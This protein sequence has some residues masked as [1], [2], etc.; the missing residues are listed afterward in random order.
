MDTDK[1]TDDVNKGSEDTGSGSHSTD[2]TDTSTTITQKNEEISLAQLLELHQLGF[3][4]VP[5]G[6]HFKPSI[7]WTPVYDNPYHWTPEKLTQAHGASKF[8]NGVATVFGKTRLSDEKGCLYL[9]ALD[10]DSDEV[11]KVLFN[12]ANGGKEYSF[13]A[14]A[15]KNTYV[16]KT[17]KP[18]GFHIYWLSHKQHESV[19]TTDCVHCEFEIKSDKRSGHS[20]LPPSRH[21]EDT[22][23]HYKNYGQQKLF[24]SDNMYDRLIEALKHCLKAKRSGVGGDANT[25]KQKSYT[26]GENTELDDADIQVIAE[27]ILPY[28]KKGRRHPIVFGLSGVLHKSGISRDS[29]IALMEELAKNDKESDVRNAVST[30]EQT[31]GKV[32]N[33]VPGSKYFLE[34]LIAATEDSGIA[35]TILDKIFRIIGK[36]DHIQWLT[37]EIMNEY[38]FK[39]MTDNED[40]Y[41]YDDERGQEWCIKQLSQ[42]LRVKAVHW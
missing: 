19:L 32:V 35:K 36:G 41:C 8:K 2:I 11:Y 31:F 28:Y 30:V 5:L 6:D 21:R 16:T 15:I 40:I 4:L 13:I 34:A 10:I 33:I 38:T 22:G 1:L 42:R 39:T 17:R 25:N 9:H 12:L 24:V 7:K 14:E 20:T 37:N 27:C 18:N 23:L 29:A 3:K 26:G